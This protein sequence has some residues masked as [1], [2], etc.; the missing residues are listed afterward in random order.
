MGV[1]EQIFI[2]PKFYKTCKEMSLYNFTQY[3]ESND[4]KWFSHK[5]KTY[6]QSNEI[7]VNFFTEYIELTQNIKMTNRF[8]KM[9][10]MMKIDIKYRGVILLLK[11]IYSNGLKEEQI[12]ESIEELRKWKYKIYKEK[13]LFLQ[14]DAIYNRVQNL[15]TQYELLKLDLEKEDKKEVISIE[16]QLIIVSKGLELGYRIDPKETTVFEWHEYQE[17]LKERQ[18]QL[19]QK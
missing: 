19:K 13:D 2:K 18:T 12:Q 16:K 8:V 7:M 1:F 11:D 15:K 6:K 10:K 14:L 4:L 9:H 3:L 17:L 5:L